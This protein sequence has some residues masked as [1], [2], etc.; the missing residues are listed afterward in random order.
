MTRT[1][2]V[3]HKLEALGL[4]KVGRDPRG[5][6]KYAAT[7]TPRGKEILKVLEVLMEPPTRA[8]PSDGTQSRIYG[9]VKSPQNYVSILRTYRIGTRRGNESLRY[10]LRREQEA[11]DN[12][13][14]RLVR[15]TSPVARK[16]LY[17]RWVQRCAELGWPV[18][19]DRMF[20][21]YLDRLQELGRVE[22]ERAGVE[23]VGGS[24]VIV[25]IRR[26]IEVE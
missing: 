11:R 22:Q 19:S 23:K 10:R 16:D 14:V 6:N 7:P 15:G 13:I 18:V 21:R 3:V 9:F 12:E 2:D 1:E 26:R 17:G 8:S 25:R 5:R 4:V 24:V 20:S